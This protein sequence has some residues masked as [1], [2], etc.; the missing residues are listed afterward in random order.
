[1]TNH[2]DLRREPEIRPEVKHTRKPKQFARGVLIEHGLRHFRETGELISLNKV[3]G[4]AGKT[5]G[6]GYQL[7]S[8]GMEKPG[9]AWH[10]DL[11]L[12]IVERSWIGD[13][14]RLDGRVVAEALQ[15][16]WQHP[17]VAAAITREIRDVEA[18]YQALPVSDGGQAPSVA[19]DLWEALKAQTA[20]P[21]RH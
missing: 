5:T 3:C 19:L 2:R 10:L 17:E 11:A 4:L 12:A 20:G 1:M 13:D 9:V 18:Y 8:A 21:R 7:Y 16:R 6:Y 15:M 14:G